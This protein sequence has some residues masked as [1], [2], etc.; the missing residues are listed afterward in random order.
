[1][2]IISLYF[3][4][5]LVV[6][7]GY[8]DIHYAIAF[9]ASMFLAAI[10]M[11]ALGCLS[12]GN[13]RLN[14]HQNKSGFLS[15][16]RLLFLLIF[17]AGSVLSVVLFALLP[18]SA[19][20]LILILFSLSNF[21]YEGGMV[22]YNAL[23]QAVSDE[24]NV[25]E[26]SGFGVALGYMG[27]IVGMILVS[28]FV[29]GEVFGWKVPLMEG[30]GRSAA[31]LPTAIFFALF[32]V[33]IFLFVREKP[34]VSAVTDIDFNRTK[35]LSG[36]YRDIWHS[37]KATKKYPGLLRF[38]IADF[39]FEDAI[40]SVIIFMAVFTNRLLGWDSAQMNI[41][42]IVSTLSAMLGAYPL[43][44]LADYLSPKRVLAAMVLGWIIVLVLFSLNRGETLFWILGPIVGLL[45]GGVW[46]TSRPLLMRLSPP[47]RLGEFFGLFS[48]SGRSAAI[49]GPMVWGIVVYFFSP[50]KIVGQITAKYITLLVR[51]IEPSFVLSPEGAA[52]LPYR[53][54][55][56]SLAA[57]VGI[58]FM[59]LKKVPD[60]KGFDRSRQGC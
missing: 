5:W 54:A 4:V 22:F 16:R 15:Q 48:L 37:L 55:I 6:D 8:K 50:D 12:D 17:T 32:S 2:N 30:G 28:P 1:M 25:G 26:V 21:F 34:S 18:K 19:I 58:G 31:F 56:L 39:F 29:T 3:A 42:L 7:L 35:S 13:G 24:N 53:L 49:C 33:P 60:T 38:L 57:L 46:A 47:E 41:F 45:L 59:I 51:K 10:L 43:G 14:A 40:A 11:P 20:I 36:A 9:S 23:L 27:S 52:Q 44:R